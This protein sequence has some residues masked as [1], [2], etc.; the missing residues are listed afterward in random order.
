MQIID[1]F[2]DGR[3]E[4]WQR[5]IATY[6]WRAAKYLA[7]ILREGRFHE[8]LGGGTLLLL[9]DG[10]A[11]VSFLTLAQKDCIA[12]EDLSPW[13]GFVHTAP[14]YRGRG[15]M[16][17]LIAH[18]MRCAG[19]HGARQ[20]YVC[21]D[22]VGLYERYGFEYLENRI[23]IY[24]ED[25][26]VYVRSTE[27]VDVRV[28]RLS[29]ENFGPRSLDDFIRE[30]EVREC[31]R[32]TDDGWQ[33]VPVSF[34]EQWDRERLR[35]EAAELIGRNRRGMPVFVACAGTAVIGFAALGGRLGSEGQYLEL[36]GYHVS[37]PWRGRGAGKLLFEAA[38][39]AAREQGAA[40]LYI[41]AHSSKESQAVYRAL[42]C[43]LA[44]EPDPERVKAEPF[45]VQM[46][47]DLSP[48]IVCK[49]ANEADIQQWMKLVR[50][51][52]WNFPGLE[53]EEALQEYERT[54]LRFMRRGNAVCAVERGRMI[55]VLLYSHKR[56]LLCCMA[57]AADARRRGAGQAMF[58][59]MLT[60]ADPTRDLSVTT[61]REEDP[62][63]VAPRAFYARQ[64]FIPAELVEENGYP[65]QRFVRRGQNG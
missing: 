52:A 54:T 15:C 31:W 8:L 44:A 17:R 9:V 1:Y 39:N 3:K 45:D 10:D 50:S 34:T 41:S 56:N 38:C 32:C 65:C 33:L 47:F 40:K 51:V 43:T 21:T 29:E 36:V 24:G 28:E 58:D 12:C 42:G 14:G 30:Q 26:R 18:A 4:H 27:A 62:K 22:H 57:V 5:Q 49:R 6:E 11:L 63:G 37:S 23:S 2:K 59:L 46:E 13:I 55:G 53:T 25:S 19:E 7:Q 60:M 16:G 64:G 35:E 48:D 20:V 61:F